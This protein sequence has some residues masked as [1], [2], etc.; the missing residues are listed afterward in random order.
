MIRASC[1]VTADCVIL[2]HTQHGGIDEHQW[3]AEQEDDGMFSLVSRDLD[4][5]G[6][7]GDFC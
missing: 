4:C 5:D 2:Y 7:D 6:G 1:E 3:K